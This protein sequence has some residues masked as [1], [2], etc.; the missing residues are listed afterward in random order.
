MLF[1]GLLSTSA[2]ASLPEGITAYKL[3]NYPL[4]L[5]QLKPLASKGNAEAQT[6]LAAMYSYG[7]GVA[8]D[9]K[10][11]LM[12]FV[13]AAEQGFS[14]AQYALGVKFANGIGVVK[15][16]GDA[17]KWFR[18]A[19][20]NGNSAAE[21]RLLEMTGEIH[22]KAPVEPVLQLENFDGRDIEDVTHTGQR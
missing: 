16:R 1:F 11:S 7:Y 20:D 13:L 4:A 10:K 18:L 5:S 2:I 17:L 12:W 8:Q 15:N 21:E 6:Y 9:H 19:A 3:G 22:L 14:K